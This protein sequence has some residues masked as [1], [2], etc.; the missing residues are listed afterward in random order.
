MWDTTA[1]CNTSTQERPSLDAFQKVSFTPLGGSTG[2][3]RDVERRGGECVAARAVERD[4]V[5]PDGRW[6]GLLGTAA[7]TRV[8]VERV[9]AAVHEEVASGHRE[10]GGGEEQPHA[11]LELRV[12]HEAAWLAAYKRREVARKQRI[13][14]VALASH[15]EL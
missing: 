4:G 15:D 8:V 9:G 13:D 1:G 6:D 12:D 3:E 2:Q 11:R 5:G 10:K 14:A 7:A